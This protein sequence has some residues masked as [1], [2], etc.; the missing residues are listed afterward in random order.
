MSELQESSLGYIT[1]LRSPSSPRVARFMLQSMARGLLLDVKPRRSKRFRTCDC[2]RKIAPKWI[3]GADGKS[4]PVSRDTVEVW[5]SSARRVAAFRNLQVCG[6]IWLCAVCASR[7]TEI[8]AQELEKIC[9][10]EDYYSAMATFTVSHTKNDRLVD[11][12]VALLGA[13]RVFKSGK[14]WQRLKR[15]FGIVGTVKGLEVTYGKLNGWHVHLHVLV[16]MSRDGL[17]DEDFAMTKAFDLQHEFRVRWLSLLAD[18]DFRPDYDHGCTVV[19]SWD[20]IQEYIAKYGREPESQWTQ[21]REIAKAAAKRGR[22]GA[23]ASSWSLLMAAFLSRSHAARARNRRLWLEY[24]SAFEGRHQLDF[25]DGLRARFGLQALSDIEIADSVD[26]DLALL[27]SLT[28]G[29][30]SVVIANDKRAEL[31]D[32]ASAGNPDLLREWLARL[33]G[34]SRVKR[35][36]LAVIGDLPAVDFEERVKRYLEGL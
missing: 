17:S 4:Y 12:L 5:A 3:V 18:G 11:L 32:V 22:S 36:D 30:W 9:H 10:H 24:V 34:Y 1:K 26:D 20:R 25:S 7:I 19:T 33:P 29:Q 14:G 13:F 6:A 28:W 16:V 8:R 27:G 15:L 35:V 21:E 31:L 23:G 2:M